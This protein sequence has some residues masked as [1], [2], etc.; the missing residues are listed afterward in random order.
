M[1]NSEDTSGDK[2]SIHNKYYAHTDPQ[3]P[4]ETPEEGGNWQELKDHLEGTAKLAE[5][6]ASEFGAGQWGYIA[7][8]L[9]DLGKFSDAF[10]NKLRDSTDKNIKVDHSTFGAQQ[11]SNKWCNGEGKIFGYCIAG[12]H[13][14]LADGKSNSESCL[15]KRLCKRLPYNFHTPKE[16]LNQQKPELPF[17]LNSERAFFEISFFIRML[18]SCLVDADFL[19]TEKH[20]N[21]KKS[22][23]RSNTVS[24]DYLHGKL[25]EYLSELQSNAEPTPVNKIRASI[26]NDC[27]KAANQKPG[28]FSL[29]V[30]TGGG[31]TLSSMGF[32]LKHAGKY[33]HKRIIY[34]IPYTS[35]IEQ[36]TDVFRNIFGETTVLEHH[37]NFEPDKKQDDDTF[38]WWK[39]AAENWDAPVIVTTSVQFFESLLS[40]QP[41]RCRKIHNIARS[42]VI[43]DEAQ[44]LPEEY[45]RPCIEI[46]RELT[47]HYN[48][49][50]VLCS[51]TQPAIQK[52]SDFSYGLSNVREIVSDPPSL[53]KKMKRVTVKHIG[54]K[55]D[56]DVINKIRKRKQLLCIVNTKKRARKLYDF[57]KDSE[58]IF[59]L[60]G[61][62]YP[63]HRSQKLEKI[64][65]DLNQNKA[66]RVISTQLIE[67]GVDI[68]F[69]VVLREIAGIDSIAQAAGRCN[70]EGKKKE[71]EVYI[72]EP[73]DKLPPGYFRH[74]A[75]TAKSVINRY[76][77][78]ILSLQAIEEYF[79]DYYWVKGSQQLDKK[80]ILQQLKA[81][82]SKLNFPFKKI[83]REFNFIENDTK[84]VIIPEGEKV[85][86]LVE[87]V[88]YS[89]ELKGYSR[90]FQRYTVQIHPFY[91]DKLLELGKIE[92][93]QELFPV[94]L[95]K[96]MYDE[97]T[98]LNIYDLADN[99]DPESLCI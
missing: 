14:G 3:K 44:C 17:Q 37:S 67:A 5:K 6:F 89:T 13:S 47:L 53:A 18:Y 4:T 29:T 26:L 2:S 51:A 15:I 19:D 45:L 52:R 72:Y 54:E 16:I 88:R 64:Q 92:V 20:M 91:W 57:L 63:Q 76:P 49:S 75:Q 55:Q 33:K 95:D 41:S 1:G 23:F 48:S 73:E 11:L 60:S 94:L 71:G 68:D 9:H 79:R 80:N 82:T 46:I 8:L 38:Q 22:A 96:S 27:L 62:M 56:E 25:E 32:A 74:T 58:G 84:P 31:K 78:D 65:E 69:P 35:I 30:P 43:L 28:L 87:E 12:H 90:K 10:Q 81:G 83:A 42:I 77:E 85:C 66:C 40:S 98:G 61:L 34:V 93:I 86:K 59:H 99:P 7:G 50:V 70:R 21:H 97:E 24:L 39:L 36:N